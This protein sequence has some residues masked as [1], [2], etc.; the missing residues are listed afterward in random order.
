MRRN[1]P[2]PAARRRKARPTTPF[3]VLSS[4]APSKT[5]GVNQGTSK[6]KLGHGSGERGYAPDFFR[7]LADRPVGGKP[8]HPRRVQDALAPPL[9]WIAPEIVDGALR[10]PVGLEIH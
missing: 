8:T 6:Q 2:E 7:V 1:P 3:R 5:P 9:A 10:R 4:M